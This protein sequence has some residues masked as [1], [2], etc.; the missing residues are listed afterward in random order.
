MPL[1]PLCR[2]WLFVVV[3]ILVA[4]RVCMTTPSAAPRVVDVAARLFHA[5]LMPLVFLFPLQRLTFIVLG[6]PHWIYCCLLSLLLLRRALLS[7]GTAMAQRLQSGGVGS[8]LIQLFVH[9]MLH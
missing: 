7:L 5:V 4:L 1:L 8:T 3:P 2:P 6:L 9:L